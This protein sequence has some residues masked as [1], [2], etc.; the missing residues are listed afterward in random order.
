[1]SMYTVPQ[2]S[3]SLSSMSHCGQTSRQCREGSILMQL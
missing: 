1:V 2:E 3:D